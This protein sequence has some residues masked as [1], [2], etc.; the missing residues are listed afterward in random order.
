MLC[1][2]D[3]IQVIVLG[4]SIVYDNRETSAVN[5]QI[6]YLAKGIY[7]LKIST[8]AGVVTRRFSVK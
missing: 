7:I 2:I 3:A 8:D 4:G 1:V 5:S 6:E